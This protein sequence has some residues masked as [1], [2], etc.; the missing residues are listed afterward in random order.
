[1][2]KSNPAFFVDNTFNILHTGQL[3]SCYLFM[4]TSLYPKTASCCFPAFLIPKNVPCCFF[5]SSIHFALHCHHP[6][7]LHVCFFSVCVCVCIPHVS[8]LSELPVQSV[9]RRPESCGKS[10]LKAAAVV[11]RS[12]VCVLLWCF[13]VLDLHSSLTHSLVRSLACFPASPYSGFGSGPL[14]AGISPGSGIHM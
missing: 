5:P 13:S 10:S 14:R 9:E 3:C 4:F 8:L 2:P 1:M 6:Y 7:F 12:S 11:A